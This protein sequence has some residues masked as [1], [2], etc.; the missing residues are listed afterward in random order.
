MGIGMGHDGLHV[1]PIRGNL[2]D[3][4]V[5]LAGGLDG[6]YA[7]GRDVG[8]T[9]DMPAAPVLGN[10]QVGLVGRITPTIEGQIMPI[11]HLR[12]IISPVNMLEVASRAVQHHVQWL[13]LAMRQVCIRRAANFL[14]FHSG[15]VLH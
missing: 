8:G 3:G 15:T 2:F 1:Q 10:A 11:H 12:L 5:K 6:F 7:I 13:S 14:R 9:P 4:A